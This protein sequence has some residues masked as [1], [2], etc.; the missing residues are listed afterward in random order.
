M[1]AGIMKSLVNQWHYSSAYLVIE[2][3]GLS[4][5]ESWLALGYT[6]GAM[7]DVAVTL[8]ELSYMLLTG[9]HLKRA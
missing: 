7:L 5:A 3:A 6:Q 9:L 2:S 8:Y 4:R 1:A